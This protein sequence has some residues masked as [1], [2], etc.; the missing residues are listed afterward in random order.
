MASFK[1]KGSTLGFQ[2]LTEGVHKKCRLETLVHV[3]FVSNIN[4]ISSFKNVIMGS[5]SF[6]KLCIL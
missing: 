5:K 3:K 2:N 4:V 1:H 6:V